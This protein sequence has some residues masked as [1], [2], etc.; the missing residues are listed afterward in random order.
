MFVVAAATMALILGFYGSFDLV[1]GPHCSRLLQANSLFVQDIKVTIS[2][3]SIVSLIVLIR[4]LI[5]CWV[6]TNKIFML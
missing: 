6:T 2:S 5:N 3:P 1:L 4:L